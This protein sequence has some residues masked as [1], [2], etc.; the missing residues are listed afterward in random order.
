MI[1]NTWLASFPKSGNTWTRAF[2]ANYLFG[3]ED[4]V[5]INEMDRYCAGDA[6]VRYYEPFLDGD[7]SDA[8]PEDVYAIRPQAHQMMVEH[9]EG[10]TLVKIHNRKADFAGVPTIAPETTFGAVYIVRNPFDTA[11]S[12][13]N[14]IG[15][16]LD[17]AIEAMAAHDLSSPASKNLIYQDLG[18][19]SDHVT[20][21]TTAKGLYMI[22]VFYEAMLMNPVKTFEQLVSFL[23]VPVDQEK[24]HRAIEFSSFRQLASQEAEHGFAEIPPVS[25]EKFFRQ[26]KVGAWRDVLN[27]DQVEFI[28]RKHGPVMQRFRYIDEKGRPRV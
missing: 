19:W 6:D 23:R 12:Y 20:S 8:V 18:S 22:V 10:S 5:N 4:P 25:R 3:G 13:A 21:W 1:G 11:I 24:L 27:R 2:L 17:V 26:G 16:P 15:K 14:H 9:S 28:V 7:A